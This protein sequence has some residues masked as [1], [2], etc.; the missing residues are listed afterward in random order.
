MSYAPLGYVNLGAHPSSPELCVLKVFL[1]ADGKTLVSQSFLLGAIVDVAQKRPSEV[2]N[3][4]KHELMRVGRR[5]NLD[6]EANFFS[7]E[8]VCTVRGAMLFFSMYVSRLAGS[9]TRNCSLLQDPVARLE[10]L[11]D[12]TAA[13]VPRHTCTAFAKY[14]TCRN[15]RADLYA[16]IGSCKEGHLLV[17]KLKKCNEPWVNSADFTSVS[18]LK[19]LAMM[20]REL[21][22]PAGRG[23][24]LAQSDEFGQLFTS[25]L[26]FATA[27]FGESLTVGIGHVVLLTPSA[28]DG[29]RTRFCYG[30]GGKSKTVEDQCVESKREDAVVDSCGL[31]TDHRTTEKGVRATC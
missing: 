2:W 8:Q 5:A 4:L 23:S 11:W 3:Q 7:S 18:I 29:A 21:I 9:R 15:G 10:S 14:F 22:W 16:A 13:F 28:P 19:V 6:Y 25:F 27:L 20:T 24:R 26:D 31:L 12:H 30:P 1:T 17:D